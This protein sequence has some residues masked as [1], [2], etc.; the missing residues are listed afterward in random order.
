MHLKTTLA[1]VISVSFLGACTSTP[2]YSGDRSWKDGWRQGVIES[3]NDSLKWN[4]VASCSR[5]V[6]P[7]DKIVVVDPATRA[8]VRILDR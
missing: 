1:L 8:V 7:G 4:Q 6:A 3:V 5:S 2:I